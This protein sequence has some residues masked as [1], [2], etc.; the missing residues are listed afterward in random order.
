MQLKW[1][2]LFLD[3]D[4]TLMATEQHALPALVE[5]FN[6]LYGG[7]IK[8]PLTLETFCKHFH[9]SAR[10][11]LCEKLS[12]FYH[13]PVD[14]ALLYKHRDWLMMQHLEH[15][16]GVEMAPQLLETLQQLAKTGLKFA[17]VT[18]NPLSRAFAAMRYAKNGRGEELAHLFGTS[19][20]DSGDMGKPLPDVYLRAMEQCGAAPEEVAAVEDSPTGVSSAVAAGVTTFGF[21]GFCEKPEE[22]SKKLKDKGAAAVFNVWSEFPELVA[23]R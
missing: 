14:C 7:K 10:E 18:N 6:K 1:K 23:A 22:L 13:T 11:Q 19:F 5:R 17:L 12:E 8:Q 3:F 16:G 20:F 4:N 2:W 15:V 9:G 21:T